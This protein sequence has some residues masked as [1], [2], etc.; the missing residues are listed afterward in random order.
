MGTNPDP[1]ALVPL[2]KQPDLFLRRVQLPG[3]YLMVSVG[4]G[5]GLMRWA[6]LSGMLMVS[7]EICGGTGF[8]G[9]SGASRLALLVLVR[10]VK[11]ILMLVLGNLKVHLEGDNTG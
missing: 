1:S 10:A 7:G 6:M 8:T 11:V 3:R 4:D 5:C 2:P 9:D